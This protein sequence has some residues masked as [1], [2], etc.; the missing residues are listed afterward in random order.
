VV[1]VVVAVSSIDDL[2]LVST[3]AAGEALSCSPPPRRRLIL[4]PH[5]CNRLGDLEGD[6]RVH[7][8]P[9]PLLRPKAKRIVA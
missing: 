5:H 1:A 2:V 6:S 9:T 7:R 4:L 8:H 3:E